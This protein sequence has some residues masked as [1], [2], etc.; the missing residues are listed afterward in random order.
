M[1]D[2]QQFTASHGAPLMLGLA[3]HE[4]QLNSINATLKVSFRLNL[5]I[6]NS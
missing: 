1:N 4:A 5:A 3:L 6:N 2:C